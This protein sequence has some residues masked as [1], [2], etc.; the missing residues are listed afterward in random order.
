MPIR[1]Q[2]AQ[3]RIKRPLIWVL[4]LSFFVGVGFV[5]RVGC[6]MWFQ[7]PAHH[8][9]SLPSF[10]DISTF[11]EKQKRQLTRWLKIQ[12]SSGA[13]PS[14]SVRMMRADAASPIV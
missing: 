11:N 10:D 9:I 1:R 2:H 4:Y 12:V 6:R 8:Q 14:L 7:P 13:F 3:K 5:G